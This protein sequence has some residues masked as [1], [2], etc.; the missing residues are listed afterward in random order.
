MTRYTIIVAPIA[1]KQIDDLQPAIAGRVANALTVLA[2]NPFAGKALK[3][4]LKGLYSYRVGDY[5]IIYHIV[6]HELIIEVVKVMHRRESY[7]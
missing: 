4:D 5:R 1:R 7:R 3:W 6:K 2:D